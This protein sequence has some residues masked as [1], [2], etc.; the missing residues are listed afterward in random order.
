MKKILIVS[1]SFY[2]TNSPRSFRTTELAKEFARQGHDVTVL[3]H[4][5][6]E[7]H[8]GFEKKHG[9]KIDDL[10]QLKWKSPD[11][12]SSSVGYFLTRAIFRL[13]K[14]LFE[15]PDIE[16][17]FKVSKALKKYK[18]YDILISIAVPFPV[19]WGVARKWSKDK[20]TNPASLWIA[21]CGDPYM[22]QENDTFRPPFYFKYVEKWFM[23]KADYITVPVESAIPAYYPEFHPKIKVISQGFRFED[24]KLAGT[25]HG[26][27]YPYFAYAGVLIPGRRDP[28]EFL[29]FLVNY[30]NPYKFDI[31]TIHKNLVISY[32]ERSEGRIEVKDY[33]TREELLYELSKLDFVVNFE[34]AG[35]KQIPSKIIDYVIVNKPILSVNSFNF[36]QKTAEEFLNGIYKNQLFIDNPEQFR[37]ENVVNQF[38]LLCENQQS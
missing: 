7:I 31:Y 35:S 28:K 12:G 17:L 38:I 2:P 9:L 21:D 23:R 26:K 36:D 24:I 20:S 14:L 5:D 1:R 33:L 13:L 29:E 16:L 34:N 3:T 32:A 30:P 11:F 22:G 25:T 19:H 27:P 4:R 8:A 6:K 37:I 18:G 10:G 15:Y